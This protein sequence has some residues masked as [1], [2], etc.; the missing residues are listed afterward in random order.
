MPHSSNSTLAFGLRKLERWSTFSDDDRAAFVALPFT[1]RIIEQHDFLIRSGDEPS[2]CC[3]LSS[4]FVYR[5]KIV[6]DGGRQILSIHVAGDII[7]LENLFLSVSD[8]NVQALTRGEVAC[9]PRDAIRRLTHDRPRL[10]DALWHESLVAG[11]LFREWIANVGRRDAKARVAHL[12][13]EFAIRLEQ[14]GLGT[15]SDYELPMTQEELADSVGLTSVHVNRMLKSLA[16]SGLISRTNR[17]VTI[18]DWQG[19]AIAADFDRT[20]LHYH[21]SNL[22]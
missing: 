19:L 2:Q 20:Y 16:D 17:S 1:L 7:D 13:C 4:G 8:H 21:Q 22:P 5:H 14:A 12:L 11:S 3:L 9:I 6:G 18:K 10:S 15:Q